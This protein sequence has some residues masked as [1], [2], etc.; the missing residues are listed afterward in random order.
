MSAVR[1]VLKDRLTPAQNQ[2]DNIKKNGE[3][4]LQLSA[5]DLDTFDELDAAAMKN[6]KIRLQ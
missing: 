2:P 5:R 4:V 3:C 1:G 6:K